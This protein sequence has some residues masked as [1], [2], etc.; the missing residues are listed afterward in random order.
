MG[1]AA[2]MKPPLREGQ[3]DMRLLHANRSKRRPLRFLFVSAALHR[4][5]LA[6]L[7][8]ASMILVGSFHAHPRNSPAGMHTTETHDTPDQPCPGGASADEGCCIAA[9]G[10]GLFIAYE[11]GSVSFRGA[12]SKRDETSPR[13]L[14]SVSLSPDFPPPRY[15]RARARVLF[16][17]AR[18]LN[19][20]V[21]PGNA[22][23]A[24][25]NT[26]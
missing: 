2:L 24:R 14:G 17:L 15:A 6:F 23:R 22:Q 20:R 7:L 13:S 12:V 11:A 3:E 1:V 16:Q 19:G 5:M 8:T 10:C 25:K 18:H 9:A 26:S 4:M 21:N